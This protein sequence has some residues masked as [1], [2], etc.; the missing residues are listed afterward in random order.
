MNETTI[1]G[2]PCAKILECLKNRII[3]ILSLENLPIVK[4]RAQLILDLRL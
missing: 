4:G 2:D 3:K 1:R